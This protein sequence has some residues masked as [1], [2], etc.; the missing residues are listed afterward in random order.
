MITNPYPYTGKFIVLGGYDGSGKD[1]QINRLDRVLRTHYPLIKIFRP[2]PKEPT[3][4]PIGGRIYDILFDRDLEYTLKDGV[5]GKVKISDFELQRFFIED[6]IQH[7]R[8][9]IIPAL[10]SGVNIICNRGV[11]STIVYG[12]NTIEEFHQVIVRHEDMFA[13]AGVPFIWP[14][15]I[16]I[17]DVAPETALR[18]MK[19]SGKEC[20]AFENELKARRVTSNYRALAALYP[21]CKLIDAEPEGENGQKEIFLNARRYIYPLLG[22]TNF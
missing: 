2:F 21:N 5:E 13:Q 19:E 6:R 18:R 10:A 16:V 8:D 20:D 1:T 22:I 7:Y 15:L 17:Y 11:E 9:V 12:G 3:K 4:G 14:D